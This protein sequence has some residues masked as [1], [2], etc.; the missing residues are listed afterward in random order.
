MMA[1]G[2]WDG[3]RLSENDVKASFHQEMLRIYKEA[4][5]FG[6][7]PAYFLR[8]VN[9]LGGLAAAQ[10]LLRDGT[11]SDGFVRL[12]SESRLDIS[13]EAVV[14]DPRWRD[15]FTP[16]ELDVARRR[17]EDAGFKPQM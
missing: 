6:Y 8:M 11:V 4:A 2:R 1:C 17:L 15:L 7:R 13:V 10:Q 9:E 14:L 12:W 16:N 5:T 3:E